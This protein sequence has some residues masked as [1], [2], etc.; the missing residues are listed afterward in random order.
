MCNLYF[1]SVADTNWT[2]QVQQTGFFCSSADVPFFSKE[3]DA[4]GT[5]PFV[6]CVGAQ[7]RE[8]EKERARERERAGDAWELTGGCDRETG[9]NP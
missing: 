4:D 8:G 9:A 2:W 6:G 1:W 7:W 5:F 3:L